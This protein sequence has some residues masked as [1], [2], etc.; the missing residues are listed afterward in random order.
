MFLPDDVILLISS[1]SKPLPRKVISKYWVDAGIPDKAIMDT[2]MRQSYIKMFDKDTWHIIENYWL[3]KLTYTEG[4]LY[5]W[6][7]K[8]RYDGYGSIVLQEDRN[9]YEQFGSNIKVKN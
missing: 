1:Y 7:G 9:K 5:T 2:I 8:F 4:S 6:D 3:Q